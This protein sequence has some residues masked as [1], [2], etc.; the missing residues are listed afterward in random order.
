ML[1]MDG[2]KNPR[3]GT[4]MERN[5]KRW[6][7]TSLEGEGRVFSN[8]LLYFNC[9]REILGVNSS[10]MVN[11]LVAQSRRIVREVDV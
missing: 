6:E 7:P 11:S 2:R 5:Q 10:G 8:C 1:E 4:H 9:T 3:L